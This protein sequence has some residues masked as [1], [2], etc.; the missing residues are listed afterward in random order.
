MNQQKVYFNVSPLYFEHNV[1]FKYQFVF[2]CSYLWKE[3]GPEVSGSLS[4]NPKNTIT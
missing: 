4:P 1:F 2:F 3:V